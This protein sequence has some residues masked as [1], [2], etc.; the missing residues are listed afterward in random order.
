MPL[1]SLYEE[2]FSNVGTQFSGGK[3]LFQL[4]YSYVVKDK[5]HLGT[6]VFVFFYSQGD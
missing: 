4:K 2:S 6:G 5:D 3:I 1:L